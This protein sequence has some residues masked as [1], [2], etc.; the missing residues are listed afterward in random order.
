MIP[1]GDPAT[2]KQSSVPRAGS[3]VGSRLAHYQ[4]VSR[5]G[6]GGMGEVYLAE[7]TRLHRRVALKLL[8]EALTSDPEA[9]R[10][11]LR[12]ARTAAALDHPNICAIHEVGNDAGRTFIVM[13]YVEG[14]TLAAKLER[15]RP[16]CSDGLALAHQIA[17][18]LAEAHAHR[19]VHRDI[20]PAN[21]VVTPRG[22]AKVLDFGL[23]K[24]VSETPHVDT[25]IATASL[26]STPG[27]VVGTVPY[28]S[29]EQVRGE[30]V[31][32]R[33]D[34]W[35]F[36]VLL[37]ELMLGRRPFEAKTSLELMAEILMREPP[38]LSGAAS[39]SSTLERL[40]RRCLEKDPARRYQTAR[41]L[42]PD[43]AQARR[44][45]E[46][47]RVESSPDVPVTPITA[48]G[49]PA[50][51]AAPLAPSRG[52]A[53]ARVGLALL[54]AL[55]VVALAAT[56]LRL[57]RSSPS[58][59]A[60]DSGASAYDDYLRGKVL[61]SEENRDNNE[62][63][64]ELLE[65]AVARDPKLAPAWAELARA[66]Y[67]KAFYY[68]PEQAKQIYLEAKV[69]LE[70]ALA[71]DPNLALGHHVRGLLLWSQANRFPH[72]QAIQSFRRALAIDPNLSDAHHALGMVYIH[73]GLLDRARS[74]V[75]Q[76]L[77]INPANTLARF[78]LGVIH[79]YRG[80]YEDALAVLRGI[81]DEI[82]RSLV[83]RTIAQAYL[84]LG[85]MDEAAALVE[86][87]FRSYP[88]DEGGSLTAI[89]AILLAKSGKPHEA[90]E[91][92]RRAVEIGQEYGHF[93]HTAH[94]V[95]AAYALLGRADEAIHWLKVA[96]EDGFPCHT[97]Y[98]TDAFLDSLRADA[99][100]V[101]FM[102]KLRAQQERFGAGP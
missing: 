2:R 69:A 91:S 53:R 80:E 13:Q 60:P 100:F 44:E 48:P 58:L 54:V 88:S 78:R 65:R 11:F 38:S 18:A 102:T 55:I 64:I 16:S 76:A 71:L 27:V 10:R 5:L 33:T 21:V 90:E 43:L 72:E 95:A 25:Q 68:S 86:E 32:A 93:H 50:L 82:N 98:D 67:G 37:H 9:T 31:D 92:I 59:A 63:A 15:E 17:E 39:R 56:Y 96:A 1:E 89:Q 77:V 79:L 4:I 35:S 36:G 20:K 40:A 61:V 7:D 73:V 30:R 52:A 8:P 23:A 97:C 46:G 74:E 83:D 75:E 49:S 6:A 14:E 22:Q 62:Q 24:L 42:L 45:V 12:E 81:G 57:S 84:H 26:L 47:S 101:D 41:E 70:K 99:R 29:P 34:V 3:L 94:N 87:Y 19:I 85:R 66:Y 28:M 51:P